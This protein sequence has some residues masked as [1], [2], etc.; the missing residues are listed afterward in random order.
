MLF[1]SLSSASDIYSLGL[2]LFETLTGRVYLNQPPGTQAG[3]LRSDIPSWLDEL[4]A[5]MLSKMPED[6]PW[7]G[8]QISQFLREGLKQEQLKQEQMKQA[9]RKIRQER[10]AKKREE[11]E[12]KKA[13]QQPHEINRLKKEAESSLA[14]KDWKQA[15][16]LIHQLEILGV[17]GRAVANQLQS[18]LPNLITRIPT[19]SWIGVVLLVF[20]T[21]LCFS[22]GLV[23]I[24]NDNIFPLFP[25]EPALD[26]NIEV[27]DET[28]TTE[29]TKETPTSEKIINTPT[30]TPTQE[31]EIPP[32][33]TPTQIPEGTHLENS[34]YG[35]E[36]YYSD[37]F[38]KISSPFIPFMLIEAM[39]GLE[40][41]DNSYFDET[42]LKKVE[43]GIGAS[44]DSNIVDSCTD[45]GDDIRINSIPFKRVE[46]DEVAAGTVY[47]EISY[48]TK[49]QGV[50]YEI[51]FIIASGNMNM[52]SEGAATEFDKNAVLE[53]L[54]ILL[55]TFNILD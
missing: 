36:I 1:R 30:N 50:C 26:S 34:R 39:D 32:T 37:A 53:E 44:T 54:N 19:W 52:Y 48:R 22:G 8:E 33:E 20:V 28:P 16:E 4:L 49:E 42:N 45:A 29:I 6:R 23:W 12:P 15:K 31:P 25:K 46:H 27:F 41:V 9:A 18:Q 14:K 35:Y 17:E 43:V 7:N 55:S 2:V 5:S 13:D 24:N 51:G 10:I 11:R 21:I 38:R 3:E 47:E 40:L